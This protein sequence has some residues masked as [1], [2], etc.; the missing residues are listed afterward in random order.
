N[1]DNFS[2]TEYS[3]F[4][5]TTGAVAGSL[6]YA[7]Y[8]TNMSGGKSPW[9]LNQAGDVVMKMDATKPWIVASSWNVAQ[10]PTTDA[11]KPNANPWSVAEVGD[12]A[13]IVFYN[14]STIAVL[15]TSKAVDGGAPT[16][17]IDV[18]ALHQDG[19]SDGNVE[20]TSAVYVPAHERVY[21]VLGNVDL[22]K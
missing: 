17:L 11:G 7:K 5:I 2:K 12:K 16:K 9:V 13:Y 4:S 14:R 15:D 1:Y 22:N 19:D 3:A 21:V 18:S 10:P 20:L 8:G 6:Q